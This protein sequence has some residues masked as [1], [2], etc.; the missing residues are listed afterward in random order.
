MIDKYLIAS[1]LSIIDDFNEQYEGIDVCSEKLKNISVDYSEQDIVFKIGYFFGR[2]AMFER[3]APEKGNKEDG[4]NDIVVESKNIKIEV[5]SLKVQKS[6]K[7]NTRSNKTMWGAIK[8]DFDWFKSEIEQG[9]KGKRA[10][11]IGWFNATERF[12]EQMQL[13]L[14]I[15]KG[16]KAFQT[17]QEKVFYF[18]FVK[19]DK[20]TNDTRSL[21]GTNLE[22]WIVKNP[23]SKTA[24][25]CIFLGKKTDIFHLALYY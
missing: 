11:I 16:N 13:A 5:K 18:P 25:K 8:N 19:Y 22:P 10:V 14:S 6:N 20:Q 2:R 1:C 15:K 3:P 23:N 12:T 24:M 17:N 21:Y 9:C 7:G 4:K